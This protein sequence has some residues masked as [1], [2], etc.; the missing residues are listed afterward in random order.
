MQLVEHASIILSREFLDQWTQLEDQEADMLV[1]AIAG[2]A[3]VQPRQ[4]Q[5]MDISFF[6]VTCRK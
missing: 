1:S 3:G 6:S 2:K 4:A 5:V